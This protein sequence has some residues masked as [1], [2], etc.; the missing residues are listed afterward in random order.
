MELVDSVQGYKEIVE[1]GFTNYAMP[2][3]RHRTGDLVSEHSD[4]CDKC[5]WHHKIVGKIVGRVH[6]FLIGK[7][8]ELINIRPLWYRAFPLLYNVNSFRKNPGGSI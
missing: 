5:A 3:I 1:T 8:S 2:F 7:K 4:F 6:D